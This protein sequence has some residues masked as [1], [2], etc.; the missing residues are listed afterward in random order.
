[1]AKCECDQIAIREIRLLGDQDWAV[2]IPGNDQ[3]QRP[4]Q[5]GINAG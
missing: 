3:F 4:E 1:M 2:N 5:R